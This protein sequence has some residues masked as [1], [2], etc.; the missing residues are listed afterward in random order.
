MTTGCG[1]ELAETGY[2]MRQGPGPRR[3]TCEAYFEL[4]N[5][6]ARASR[7]RRLR[8]GLEFG[9]LPDTSSSEKTPE[10]LVDGSAFS[11]LVSC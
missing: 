4:I 10:S 3:R 7:R 1:N 2:A 9:R 8:H 11:R 5:D 6:S